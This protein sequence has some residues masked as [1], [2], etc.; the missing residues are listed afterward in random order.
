MLVSTNIL[1]IRYMCFCMGV[2]VNFLGSFHK[3]NLYKESLNS[4]FYEYAY[5]SKR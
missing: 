2:T 4:N 3:S 1:Y 5:S